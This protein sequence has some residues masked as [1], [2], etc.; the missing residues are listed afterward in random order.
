MVIRF[1]QLAIIIFKNIL[2][3]KYKHFGVFYPIA[4]LLESNP[5]PFL[6]DLWAFQSIKF[7]F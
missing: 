2:L 4:T 7:V 3:K 5:F 6:H 1:G